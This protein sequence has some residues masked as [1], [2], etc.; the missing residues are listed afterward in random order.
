MKSKLLTGVFALGLLL[1]L[2]ASTALAQSEVGA[3]PDY[4]AWFSILVGIVTL[5]VA[6]YAKGLDNRQTNTDRKVDELQREFNRHQLF[7]ATD[8]QTKE[9]STS[10]FAVLRAHLDREFLAVHQRL[11]KLHAPSAYSVQN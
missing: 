9:D 2:Y 6:S 11:D 1:L 8:H 4:R 3:S 5:M 10:Q 7:V